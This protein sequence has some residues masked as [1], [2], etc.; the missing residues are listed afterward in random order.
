L[1]EANGQNDVVTRVAAAAAGHYAA[2][3]YVTVYDGVVGPW[4]L[5]TFTAATGLDSLS[6]VIL[7]PSVERCVERVA[8]RQNH[9]FGNEA[10]TRTMHQQFSEADI[11]S[12][13]VLHDPWEQDAEVADFVLSALARGALEYSLPFSSSE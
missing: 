8:T 7:L 4:F 2:N 11:P 9:G 6:Y 10:A 3:G 5:P 12:R 13:H 1:P